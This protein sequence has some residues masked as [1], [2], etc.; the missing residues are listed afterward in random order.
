MWPTT[1]LTK[2][3][4]IQFPIIQAPM[5]G[6]TTTPELVAAVSN[7]G[8]LGSLGA[9]YMTATDIRKAI[10]EI[11]ALTNNPF[12]VNLFIP[13]Q[14]HVTPEQMQKA[15][16][17]VEQSCAEL[18][19]KI[20]PVAKPYAPSFEEQIKVLIEEKIPVFSFTF[21]ALDPTWITQ[22]KNNDTILIGTATTLAEARALEESGIDAIVAQGSE[23]GGHRGT[24][25]ESAEDALMNLSNL[26][27]QLV[28]QVKLPVIA[29]GGIM[30]GK[31]IV[32]ALALGAAGVQM[33]TA[34]LSCPEAGVH[35]KYKQTLLSL[36]QDNTTLT[37]AFSGKLARAIQNKFITRMDEN[38][39][40]ILDYPVQNALTSIMRKKA[41]EQDCIDFM[42]MW[43]GQSAQLSRGL[44]AGELIKQLVDEVEAC[45]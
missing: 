13:E 39:E 37:R 16:D 35:A 38:K 22:L 26:V 1:K 36:N 10:K 24:F 9:G 18:K 40:S 4:G 17:Q 6:G 5:A 25:L 45:L 32:A 30:D 28:D 23:A 43:A 14:Y 2:A 8:A 12:A 15:R 21:G 3:L 20:G 41:K 11:R 29:A 33:G 42:S 31:G 7:A 34:F 19:L 27:P 44:H